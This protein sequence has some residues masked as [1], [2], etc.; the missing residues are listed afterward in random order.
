MY[1]LDLASILSQWGSDIL[2]HC[3]AKVTVGKCFFFLPFF[4]IRTRRSPQRSD[5]ASR[6]ITLST[7][8]TGGGAILFPFAANLSVLEQRAHG[9]VCAARA[10]SCT[11]GARSR[12]GSS[13]RRRYFM[14]LRT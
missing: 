10:V 11:L 3:S 9:A 12:L 14:N 13:D 7:L 4:I 8:S 5:P 2:L 6:V 1:L